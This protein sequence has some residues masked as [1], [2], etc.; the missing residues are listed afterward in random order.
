MKVREKYPGSGVWWVFIYRDN[1]RVSRRVGSRAAAR[2]VAKIIEGSLAA[3][4]PLLP[5]RKPPAPTLGEYYRRFERTYCKTALRETTQSMYESSFRRHILPRLGHK[6]L[7][8]I[9]RSDVEE[10]IS[11]LVN[12]RNLARTS[13]R[14]IMSQ[15]TACL[16]HAIDHGL[17][18]LNP[19]RKTS[20]L[21]KQ[22]PVRHPEIQ[23]LSA[24][25]VSRFLEAALR[26]AP[27]NY[28]LF[29]AAMHTG[30]RSGE[31]AAL[32]WG[33][34]DFASLYLTV[35][36]Q[37]VRGDVVPFTKTGRIR[38]VDL[39]TTL[40]DVLKRLRRARREEWLARGITAIPAWVFANR[41]GNPPDMHNLKNR[42]FLRCLEKAGLRRI[43]FHDI[44]HTFA[45]LLIQNGE[46]LAYVKDQ[47]GHSSI[48]LTVDTYT[49][50]I[51]GSNREAM[52]RLP[53]ATDATPLPKAAR[54]EK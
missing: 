33:D 19:T 35:R 20:R 48:K 30:L 2:R 15:L 24:A 27:H 26:H 3:G 28:P 1:R 36:R 52:D 5:E 9:S 49:H 54:R 50:W 32:Q 40:S 21:Y 37:I 29:L 13:V 53:T 11:H 7:D 25:E 23:S 43:R 31:L 46:P 22:A 18:S 17:L 45:T 39:S 42:H 38:R 44:R 47:L 16:N 6:P 34:I 41:A 12:T 4:G 51:P 10:F 8:Q 14:I